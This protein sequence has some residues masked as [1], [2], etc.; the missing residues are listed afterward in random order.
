MIVTPHEKYE[1]LYVKEGDGGRSPYSPHAEGT[2][3]KGEL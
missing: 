2:L 3:H 1:P